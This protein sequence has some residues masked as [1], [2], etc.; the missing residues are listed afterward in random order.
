[1]TPVVDEFLSKLNE[2]ESSSGV[3]G[4]KNLVRELVRKTDPGGGNSGDSI[5]NSFPTRQPRLSQ[6]RQFRN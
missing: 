4:V 2:I 1:M 6:F 5:F 3:E